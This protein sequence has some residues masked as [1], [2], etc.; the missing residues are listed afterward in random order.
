MQISQSCWMKRC[1]FLFHQMTF[2]SDDLKVIWWKNILK[3]IFKNLHFVFQVYYHLPWVHVHTIVFF[4]LARNADATTVRVKEKKPLAPRV[5][6]TCLTM[7]RYI[8][9]LIKYLNVSYG[10]MIALFS[11]S[12]ESSIQKSKQNLIN[13]SIGRY[14]GGTCWVFWL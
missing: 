11:W 12:F 8:F 1:L 7:E 14:L 3:K 2:K 5:T 13:E 10:W 9:A 6:I 4:S